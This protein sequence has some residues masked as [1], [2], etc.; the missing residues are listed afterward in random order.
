MIETEKDASPNSRIVEKF[1][2]VF[3]EE[4]VVIRSPGRVN[5]IGEHT[6]YNNGF[7][8]PAAISKAIYM[9]VSRRDDNELHFISVDLDHSYRGDTRHIHPSPLQWPDYILG[10]I[11]QLQQHGQVIGGFNCVFGG[12]IPPGA[13]MSSSAALECATMYS[14][15][16]L[17]G[18]GLDTLTMVKLSQQAEN[19]F[20]KV[21]CGIMDQFASMFGRKQQVIRLDCQSLDYEYLPFHEDGIAIL[22]LDTR[23]KHSLASSEYN[24]RRQQCEAGVKLIRAHH[25]QV[26]SL[27]DALPEMVDRYVAPVDPVLYKRCRYVV[28]E[29]ARLLAGCEDLRNGDTGAFGQKMFAT[30]EGLSL[31]Y[32]V[33]CP[34]L[35]FLVN[36]VKG[37]PAVLG[38]R[39]MG[40]G[41][42][43][44]TIN[45]VKE[46]AIE[47][48]VAR[49]AVAYAKAMNKE[50]K[51]YEGHIDNGTS[52][53]D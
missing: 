6:D 33:S 5:L 12:D 53:I 35:D 14:L 3:A 1:K 43:G 37:N 40:G 47:E 41:F 19:E 46:D 8:L 24:T 25:P 27:R 44:C 15:N 16:E 30:H 2:D 18:L 45:L 49:T 10:V 23:V 48:L 36:E 4:P 52:R 20:V 11:D 42:G 7:V 50:L 26:H 34:E 29:N 32:E 51:A 9:A 21:K 38:A 13:G 31:Q 28:D 22:L 17:F 39:M